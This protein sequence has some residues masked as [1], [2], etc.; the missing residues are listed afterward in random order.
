METIIFIDTETG[1]TNPEKH[2]LL[3]VGLVAWN[4]QD[5]IFDA[6]EVYI[7]SNIYSFTREA[8]RINKFNLEQH[9]K[10]AV[11]A[12]TAVEAIRS[13]AIYNAKK[14]TGIQIA[15]HNIQFDVAFLKKLFE[16]QNRSF[17]RLFSHRMIDTFSILKF[18]EDAGKI[19]LDQLSSAGAFN[20]YGIKVHGRHSALGDAIATAELYEALL[21]S[22][23]L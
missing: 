2:S 16:E 21:K 18:L 7:K 13:F 12:K 5:G 6:Q 10:L 22:E 8:Q 4:Q 14:R 1:G 9:N 3:S 17:S 20:H 11:S 19:K 15:G 23:R